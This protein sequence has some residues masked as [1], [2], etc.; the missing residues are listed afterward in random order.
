MRSKD[1][2]VANEERRRIGKVSASIALQ[3]SSYNLIGPACPCTP[4]KTLPDS[5]FLMNIH[6][7]VGSDVQDVVRD[8][9]PPSRDS[10]C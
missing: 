8:V 10:P 1:V 9:E 4:R 5:N 7:V 3:H 2:A 6:V